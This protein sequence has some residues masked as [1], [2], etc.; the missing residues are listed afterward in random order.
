MI[1]P[2]GPVPHASD[3]GRQ[4]DLTY[5]YVPKAH[6][7]PAEAV[8]GLLQDAQTVRDSTWYSWDLTPE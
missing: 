2:R 4:P 6:A 3:R 8:S 1:H 5:S 7:V